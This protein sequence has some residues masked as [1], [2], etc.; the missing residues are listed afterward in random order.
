MSVLAKWILRAFGWRLVGELP[1]VKKYVIIVAPHTSNWDFFIFVMVKFAFRIKVVFIGKHTIF[2]GPF[3][4]ILRSLGGLPVNRDGAHNVV[5]QIVNEFENRN[6]MIFVLSP[7]GTRSYREHW[8]SGFY[9]IARKANVPVLTAFLDTNT[10]NLGW[11]PVFEMSDD[12]N[13]DLKK[14]AEFY[15]DKIAIRPEKSSKIVFNDPRN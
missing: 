1:K 10:K 13:A 8:K 4:W 14:I 15:S 2:V 7:E 12:K 6:E 3:D 5:G 11:G 9:H